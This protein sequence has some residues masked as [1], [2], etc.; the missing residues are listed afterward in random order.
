MGSRW[1]FKV[2]QAKNGRI[3]NYKARFVANRYSQVERIDYEETFALVARYTSIRTVI[4]L[5]AQMGW[6]IHQTDVKTDFLNGV[7]KEEG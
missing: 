5:V 4:S 6:E 7:I 1:L 2:K 3:E